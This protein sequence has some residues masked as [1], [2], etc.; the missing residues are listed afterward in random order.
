M[1]RDF[2][3]PSTLPCGTATD[4]INILIS[5]EILYLYIRC[6][7]YFHRHRS[8]RASRSTNALKPYARLMAVSLCSTANASSDSQLHRP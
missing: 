1:G 7:A 8:S 6:T 3:Q 4:L 5:S 2:R